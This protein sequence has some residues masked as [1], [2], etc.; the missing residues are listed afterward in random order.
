[1]VDLRTIASDQRERVFRVGAAAP[2]WGAALPPCGIK[3]GRLRTN[4]SRLYKELESRQC[5]CGS[6][7]HG[8][9]SRGRMGQP[10]DS[11]NRAT[12]N[13]SNGLQEANCCP[14]GDKFSQP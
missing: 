14:L 7:S 11:E 1:M 2:L 4:T 10:L 13:G 3:V 9:P 5:R 8:S 6:Q 12:K